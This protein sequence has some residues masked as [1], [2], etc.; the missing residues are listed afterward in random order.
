MSW[1]WSRAPVTPGP[2]RP[3]VLV[4]ERDSPAGWISE[5]RT[6]SRWHSGW[7]AGGELVP[8]LFTRCGQGVGHRDSAGP[9]GLYGVGAVTVLLLWSRGDKGTPGDRGEASAQPSGRSGAR[10]RPASLSSL[11]PAPCGAAN[12]AEARGQGAHVWFPQVSRGQA[13]EQGG[14]WPGGGHGHHEAQHCP[15]H[16]GGRRRSLGPEGSGVG[17]VWVGEEMLLTHLTTQPPWHLISLGG[18]VAALLFI[19]CG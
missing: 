3:R 12:P 4:F 9:S 19:K 5:G 2:L 15:G 16:A 10:K 11:P 6:G 17:R 18:E 14:R 1:T 13:T 7:A 8:G